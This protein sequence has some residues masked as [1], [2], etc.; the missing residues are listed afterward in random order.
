VVDEAHNIY[1]STPTEF[2]RQVDGCTAKRL[3]YAAHAQAHT[4]TPICIICALTSITPVDTA[5]SSLRYLTCALQLQLK[6]F[7]CI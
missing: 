6:T 3:L 5:Q 7:Q 1:T 4:Y 2:S